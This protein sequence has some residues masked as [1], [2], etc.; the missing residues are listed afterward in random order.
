MTDPQQPAPT[1]PRSRLRSTARGLARA[2]LAAL[3]LYTA[4]GSLIVGAVRYHALNPVTVPSL[5]IGFGALD[6]REVAIVPYGSDAPAGLLGVPAW[7]VDLH[8]AEVAAIDLD[9]REELWRT[10]ISTGRESRQ[11]VVVAVGDRLAY[12]ADHLGL[13]VL[14]LRTG[15]VVAR[16]AGLA[17]L[18][19]AYLASRTAYAY[20]ADERAVVAL[21][22]RGEVL[23]IPLDDIA[24]R[25]AG[26]STAARW[27]DRLNLDDDRRP[28]AATESEDV[29][30]SIA[31]PGR[32]DRDL[33]VENSTHGSALRVVD[34]ATGR[35]EHTYNSADGVRNAVV[36]PRGRVVVLTADEVD[37]VLLGSLVVVTADGIHGCPVGDVDFIGF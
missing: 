16:G 6:G 33:V 3:A 14:D 24:A 32:A 36:S 29:P 18:G 7:L 10:G 4:M 11:A 13:A 26:E 1:T 19:G 12:V 25:P 37:G 28:L 22:A 31:L 2:A 35:V 5:D 34:R 27:R 17:G 23:A 8:H 15:D 21:T 9:T 30:E 20:D